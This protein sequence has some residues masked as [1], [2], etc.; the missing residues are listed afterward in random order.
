MIHV[1][2]TQNQILLIKITGIILKL[3]TTT[4]AIQKMR[5]QYAVITIGRKEAQ[6]KTTIPKTRLQYQAQRP[7]SPSHFKTIIIIIITFFKNVAYAI[8]NTKYAFGI[9]SEPLISVLFLHF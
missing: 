1:K 3:K 6:V 9:E 5:L 7:N 2:H 4:K 8:T